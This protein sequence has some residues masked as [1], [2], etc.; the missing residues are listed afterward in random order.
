MADLNFKQEI[1]I[2]ALRAA[3]AIISAGMSQVKEP[4][5]VDF[6]RVVDSTIQ[7][8]ESFAGWIAF[9]NHH[10]RLTTPEPEDIQ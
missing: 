5:R 8:S 7:L 10:E 4:S 2:E 3:T 9:G 1:R 6:D